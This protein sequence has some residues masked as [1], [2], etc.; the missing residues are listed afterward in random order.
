MRDL[1]EGKG[2]RGLEGCQDGI[3]LEEGEGGQEERRT[4]KLEERQRESEREGERR[5]GMHKLKYDY[6]RR[7]NF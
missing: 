4:E 3:E 1:E 7:K 2:K 6:D 5:K